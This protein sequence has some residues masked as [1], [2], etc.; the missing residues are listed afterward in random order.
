MKSFLKYIPLGLFSVVI[1]GS[2]IGK[3]MTAPPLTEAFARLGYPSYLLIILGVAYLLGLV[4]LWQTKF[5]NVK[6]WAFAGF[7]IAMI[8]AFGSH[9]LA[10]DPISA[11]APS[12][13]LLA[14]L[15]ASYPLVL[16]KGAQA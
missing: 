8:G 13:I 5:S 15:V 7:L 2:V 3:L 9:M 12:L 10:G 14:L 4:G 1:A 11:A 6:E 16:K